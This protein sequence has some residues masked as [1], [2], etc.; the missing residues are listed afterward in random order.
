MNIESEVAYGFLI[1]STTRGK[2]VIVR[3]SNGIIALIF[4]I[5]KL[6][7]CSVGVMTHEKYKG[8]VFGCCFWRHI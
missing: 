4:E 1:P 8:A 2:S 7:V 3:K 5:S 6:W